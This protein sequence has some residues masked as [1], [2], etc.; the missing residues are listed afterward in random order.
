MILYYRKN[1]YGAVIGARSETIYKNDPATLIEVLFHNGSNSPCKYYRYYFL[2][3]DLP[4]FS[5][6]DY[7][8]LLGLYFDKHSGNAR[9][10]ESIRHS[11]DMVYDIVV[12][13]IGREHAQSIIDAAVSKELK[14]EIGNAINIVKSVKVDHSGN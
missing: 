9:Q 1:N 10:G 3:K 7:D 12:G 2:K 6:N 5:E 4:H 14:A 11:K 8:C 13:N